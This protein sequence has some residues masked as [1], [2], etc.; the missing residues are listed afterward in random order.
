MKIEFEDGA[1]IELTTSTHSHKLIIAI[2]SKN[3]K[4]PLETVVNSAEI[5]LEQFNQLVSELNKQ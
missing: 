1:Y 5:T 4:N 2:G 3:A